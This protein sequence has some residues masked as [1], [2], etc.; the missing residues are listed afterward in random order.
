[1][2]NV[3]VPRNNVRRS[4]VDANNIPREEGTDCL[5]DYPRPT[6][7]PAKVAH[8]SHVNVNNGPNGPS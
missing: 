1:M 2:Q 5:D 6:V 4:N 7:L 8:Q 3:W